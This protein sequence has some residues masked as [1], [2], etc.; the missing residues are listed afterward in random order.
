MPTSN[1][2][3]TLEAFHANRSIR[4][5]FTVCRI[6]FMNSMEDYLKVI[7][8][9]LH[10]DLV[11][12]NAL[13]HLQALAQVLPPF[14]YAGFECRLGANSSQAVDLFVSLP[15]HLNTLPPQFLTH[16]IWQMLQ[17]FQCEWLEPA[18]FMSQSVKNI[19]LEFDI[20]GQPPEVPIPSFF[21][22]FNR[23]MGSDNNM[24]TLIE[25]LIRQFNRPFSKKLEANLE[26]CLHALPAGAQI[27]HLGI[28]L[29]RPTEAVRIIIEELKSEDILDYLLQI[30][31][32]GPIDTLGNLV[33]TL[34]HLVDKIGFLNLDVS[35]LIHAQIGLE[36][37]F[38]KQPLHE[39]RWQFFFD[40]LVGN[41]LCSPSKKEAFLAWP[42][43][44]QPESEPALWPTHL[45]WGDAFF[46]E[47]AVSAFFRKI[48]HVKM[49]YHP[50]KPLEAKGYLA[51]GHRWFDSKTLEFEDEIDENNANEITRSK[52]R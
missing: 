26:Q 45:N 43:F 51:F 10:S 21:V 49:V 5:P 9:H 24:L 44:S 16:P 36:C 7:T 17:A 30:G 46:S 40:Y 32:P 52:N 50:D 42:G 27:I 33:Q 41:G 34:S 6:L 29:S 4:I 31:W 23:E 14:S 47:Q 22:E 35:Q 3:N 28:M 1:V 48:N 39:P 25:T 20:T 12:P 13:S 8:P 11:T 2:F 19:A 18:S 37:Y 38:D 15:R